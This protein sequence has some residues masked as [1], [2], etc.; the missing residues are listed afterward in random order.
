MEHL[1]RKLMIKILSMQERFE[2]SSEDFKGCMCFGKDGGHAVR[3]D[4]LET[5]F[6][7]IGVTP[8]TLGLGGPQK[9]VQT[10]RTQ[11][12]WKAT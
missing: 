12:T 4:V 2:N 9:P 11:P 8:D 5:L 3:D 6:V 7:A 1:K 10:K